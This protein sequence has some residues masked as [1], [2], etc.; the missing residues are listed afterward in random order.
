M[1][2]Y[3]ETAFG[4]LVI[5]GAIGLFI[6]SNGVRDFSL[7]SVNAA[8]MPRVTAGLLLILGAVTLI[9]SWSKTTA[10]EPKREPKRE[11]DRAKTAETKAVWPSVLA[12]MVLMT[13]YV[14]LLD[15]LGFVL[16]SIGYIFLQILLLKK[17]APSRYVTF[18]LVAI[19]VPVSAY[20]AFVHLFEV[21][22][23]AGVFG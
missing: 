5:L 19:L 9:G 11:P 14:A 10:G 2:R 3:G 13:V 6:I 22:V 7:A 4:A 8:F 23:P 16:A 17:R 20:L 21:M 1:T 15:S 18:A 12:S